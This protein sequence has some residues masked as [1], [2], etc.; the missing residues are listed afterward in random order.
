MQKKLTANTY[1]EYQQ[2]QISRST[3]KWQSVTYDMIELHKVI[4][5]CLPYIK[6]ALSICCMGIRGGEYNEGNEMA[7]FRHRPE[8]RR[9]GIF[10]VDINPLVSK[11][12]GRTFCHDFNRLPSKGWEDRFDV[13]YSNS[14]DH[15]YDVQ[16]TLKGWHKALVPGGY[17]ILG[18][19]TS[20]EIGGS[21]VYQFE[22]ADIPEICGDRFELVKKLEAG[23][24][25]NFNI[26]LRKI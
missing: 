6:D 9:A 2:Q 16:D 22:E 23:N 26:L 1:A 4:D 7:D 24:E 3:K 19:S 21:D 18:L 8:L 15:A 5:E 14:L 17:L 20:E 12:H 10:G 25:K 13:I 11:V